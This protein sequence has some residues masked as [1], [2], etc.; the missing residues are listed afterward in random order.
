MTTFH[1]HEIWGCT[2]AEAILR[3]IDF[4]NSDEHREMPAVPGAVESLQALNGEYELIAI[5]ARHPDRTEVTLEV[6]KRLF[7][8][9]F[10]DIHFLG[11]LKS[12][13]DFCVE[14]DI[15]CMVDDALHNAQS[16][17]GKGIP[18]FLLDRPWNQGT[19]P[20]NTTRVL[21]WAEIMR[22]M[23]LVLNKE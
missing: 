5:T 14:H 22:L 23:P 10:Q 17:G 15:T 7:G 18:V 8:S 19:L 9:L 1:P 6:T 21:D 13:G 3:I 20:L 2:E 4:T 11:H 16:V 12:K